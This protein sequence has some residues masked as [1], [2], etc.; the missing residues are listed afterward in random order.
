[1]NGIDVKYLFRLPQTI[2]FKPS[3]SLSLILRVIYT[4]Q[5]VLA[6]GLTGWLSLRNGRLAVHQLALDLRTETASH[7]SQYL[8]S[9]LQAA[10]Q[11]NQANAAAIATGI[12]PLNDF[13]VMGLYFWRQM[14]IYDVGYIN[15]ANEQGEFIGVE[16]TVDNQLLINETRASALDQ[17]QIFTTDSQGHRTSSITLS[18]PE[19]VTQ[20]GWYADAVTAGTTVWSDIYQWD[21]Q[22]DVLS[23]SA[24]YP[25]YGADQQLIGVIGVDVMLSQIDQFLQ[26]LTQD[27]RGTIFI[28]E[29][30]GTLVASSN[31]DR[32]DPIATDTRQRLPALDSS[33]AVVRATAQRLQDQM[34]TD[35]SAPQNVSFVFTL[36][37]VRH[38]VTATP[39]QDL[40]GINWLIVTV[41]PETEF[42]GQIN[43]NTRITML[44]CLLAAAIAVLSCLLTSRWINHSIRKLVTASQAISQGNLT[45]PLKSHAIWEF[46][47]LNQSFNAMA[48]QLRAAFNQ[49]EERVAVRTVELAAAKQQAENANQ[50]KTQFLTKVSQ[51]LRDPLNVIVGF[52]QIILDDDQMPASHQNAIWHIHH[53]GQSL[54]NLTET[55][56]KIIQM[57]EEADIYDICFDLTLFLE[58]LYTRLQPTIA[59]KNLPLVVEYLTDLPQFIYTD[60]LK[61]Q[62][63]LTNLVGIG[64]ECLQQGRIV[65]NISAKPIS[66]KIDG[67]YQYWNLQFDIKS[68]GLGSPILSPTKFTQDFI[69][70]TGE[71]NINQGS[72]LRLYI[73]REYVRLLGGELMYK[74]ISAQETAFRFVIPVKTLMSLEK[75]SQSAIASSATQSIEQPREVT[76]DD[77]TMSV[78]SCLLLTMPSEWLEQLK[79]AALK[80]ADSTLEKLIAQIP[81]EHQKL[82]CFLRAETLNFHFDLIVDVI[83]SIRHDSPH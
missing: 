43:Q 31:A 61:L 83:N 2:G 34:P 68:F 10:Q 47:H 76:E 66:S 72:E 3:L 17:M 82:I 64:V 19:P 40:A 26:T 12:L 60:E 79:Q 16:R 8:E 67:H 21:D 80:G 54:M 39:C 51:E 1:M 36:E 24:S 70:V 13:E 52:T 9:Q 81:V 4:S 45:P 71:S 53:N 28:V 77:E 23:I 7:V 73:G 20:E 65:L 37:G 6:V 29:S 5:I 41:V 69:K 35:S 14:H 27:Q 33:D 62:S 32:V 42:I 74:A 50:S 58:A 57:E 25:L 56:L 46:A 78:I 75:V 18:A 49:M 22:P 11:L 15:F 59:V 44:M 55:I 38:Y 63:I 30:D 48:N